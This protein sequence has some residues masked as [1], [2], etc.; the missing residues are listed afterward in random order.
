ENTNHIPTVYSVPAAICR[1]LQELTLLYSLSLDSAAA[2]RNLC[3]FNTVARN[4]N[5]LVGCGMALQDIRR[6]ETACCISRC[7][8]TAT[9][10]RHQLALL[11]NFS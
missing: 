9:S 4:S 7:K 6:A 1:G 11:V 3:Q 10:T 5:Y 8:A 2:W